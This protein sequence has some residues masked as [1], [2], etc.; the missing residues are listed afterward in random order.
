MTYQELLAALA[1]FRVRACVQSDPAIQIHT[2]LLAE[3]EAALRPHILYIVRDETGLEKLTI[4]EDGNTYHI[5]VL[6]R[7]RNLPEK[8]ASK[9]LNLSFMEEPGRYR[10]VMDRIADINSWE[11]ELHTNIDR[12]TTAFLSN[13]GNQYIL[14]QA[15][16]ML[17]NPLIQISLIS[18]G[19]L[20]SCNDSVLNS[21][22]GLGR[23]VSRIRRGKLT[24]TTGVMQ[25][26]FDQDS[27]FRLTG[28][29]RPELLETY[30]ETLKTNQMTVQV[31]M[32][33][34]EAAIITVLAAERAFTEIDKKTLLHLGVLVGQELQK[35]SLYSHNS[36]EIKAQFLNYLI[37]SRTISDDYI[38]QMTQ[39]RSV[40]EVKDKFYLMVIES[41]D[42]VTQRDAN[43]F[44]NLLLQIQPILVHGLYLIREAELVILF[45]LAE[46][47][48]IHALIDH[49]LIPKCRK[50]H[51]IA[52]ISNM[53]RDLRETRKYY[54]QAQKS[55]S[56]GAVYKDSDLNYFSDI[57]PKEILNFMARQ[58]DL[59][60]FCVPEVLDL[61]NYDKKNGTAL[62]DTLYVY[63]ENV[64]ST[65]P[66]A[67]ALFIHKNTLLYRIARIKEILHCDMQKGEDVYKLMMSLRILRTLM[68]YSPPEHRNP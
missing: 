13:R 33:N 10:D 11:M 21:S 8:L 19:I 16:K 18:E 22:P 40:T 53:Y 20:L 4:P 42:D 60:S 44:S 5:L 48:N 1:D 65:T 36:N 25:G 43:L 37:S 12:L 23:I 46:K 54:Q 50:Y 57:A 7:I 17:G 28:D 56:L 27:I 26:L 61:L 67:K 68:L 39:L 2:T 15:Q 59:L 41:M 3:G 30:N 31:R 29:D 14:D 35:K 34:M 55:V 52:G 62:T 45:N 64:C 6:G 9:R 66:A 63:L 47:A 58:E 24:S 38:Y 32:K 49:V 51:L